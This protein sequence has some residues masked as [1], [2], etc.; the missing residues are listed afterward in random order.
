MRGASADRLVVV[1][2]FVDH[3]V[4]VD[5]GD[6]WVI[7]ASDVTVQVA[8]LLDRQSQARGS[9]SSSCSF[10]SHSCPPGDNIHPLG[11]KGEINAI[12]F[13]R[14]I[15]TLSNIQVVTNKSSIRRGALF[16]VSASDSLQQT[17]GNN[18][19]MCYTYTRE[20]VSRIIVA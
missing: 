19:T 16:V 2:P 7:T 14:C 8:V 6:L 15:S 20:A 3:L 1:L 10:A 13:L 12:R 9:L 11:R 4:V 5:D 17:V 18:A